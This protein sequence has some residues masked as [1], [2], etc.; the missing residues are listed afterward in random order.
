MVDQAQLPEEVEKGAIGGPLFQ[1]TILSGLSGVEQRNVDW[2]LRRAQYTI[3]Y[4]LQDNGNWQIVRD[5]FIAQRGRAYAFLFKDWS[6]YFATNQTLGLGNGTATDFQLIKV[7]SNTSGRT[8]TRNITQ[9]KTG[10]IAI[11]LNGV[12]SSA[13]SLQ[14]GGVI[15][16]AAAPGSG[17][18]VMATYFEF[19]VPVRFDQDNLPVAMQTG[20][21]GAISAIKLVE[22]LE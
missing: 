5:F 13:W 10:T 8:Y 6:D 20:Q 14:P 12:S 15:R 1:T 21:A 16:F 22:V 7:Y 4:G 17:V 3:G 18:V 2:A 11:T 19:F 9:P